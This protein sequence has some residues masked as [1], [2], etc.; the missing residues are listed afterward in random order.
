[1]KTRRVF[2]ILSILFLV[3]AVMFTA[4]PVS[5]A[6]SFHFSVDMEATY[7]YSAG[8]PGNPCDFPIAEHIYGI[9]RG[10]VWVDD[11]GNMIKEID[12]WGNVHDDLS[13]NGKTVTIKVSAAIYTW[14]YFPDKIILLEKYPGTNTLVTIPHYGVIYGGAGQVLYTYTF[15][16]SWNSISVTR[17]QIGGYV[18]TDWAPVCAYLAP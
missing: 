12:Q 11:S 9:L 6:T 2:V 4:R 14:E 10:T 15:D 13:A 3:S 5:A 8:D 18:K 17:E 1:M 7:T 16:T